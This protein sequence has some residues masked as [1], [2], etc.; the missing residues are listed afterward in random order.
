MF[1]AIPW[2]M[3]VKYLGVFFF[4]YTCTT[5][6]CAVFRKFYGQFNN[7]LSVLGGSASETRL[8]FIL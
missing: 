5:D 7:I 3:K 4:G 6:L 2:P 8:H 1:S